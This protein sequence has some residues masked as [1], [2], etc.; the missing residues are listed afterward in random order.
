L[1]DDLTSERIGEIAFAWLAPPGHPIAGVA[2]DT[3]DAIDAALSGAK[4]V[5]LAGPAA[6]PRRARAVASVG[7]MDSAERLAAQ[8]P[9][10]ALLPP[11]LARPDFRVVAPS[12]ERVGVTVVYRRPLDGAAPQL[13]RAL[14]TAVR[15]VVAAR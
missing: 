2:G 3:D 5:R 11:G 6:N 10:L 4:V 7:S 9:F 1:P 13:V 12:R 15:S 14:V 8:G